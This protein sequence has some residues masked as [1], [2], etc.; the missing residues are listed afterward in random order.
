MH[1]I[2]TFMMLSR[3]INEVLFGFIINRE[4]EFGSVLKKRALGSQ[5]PWVPIVL[6]ASNSVARNGNFACGINVYKC[7]LG[8]IMC[9]V[10]YQVY[11]FGILS[12]YLYPVANRRG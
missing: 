9:A 10:L 7:T 1:G 12:M 6:R 5:N 11:Q 3:W 8:F 2:R 4:K